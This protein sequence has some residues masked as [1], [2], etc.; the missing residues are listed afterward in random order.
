MSYGWGDGVKSLNVVV[1][2]TALTWV[3]VMLVHRK[4]KREAGQLQGCM[5]CAVMQGLKLRR[6][7]PLVKCCYHFKLL[8]N[9]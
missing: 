1:L 6:A 4:T 9:F 2:W 3:R 5:T 7:P 8:N